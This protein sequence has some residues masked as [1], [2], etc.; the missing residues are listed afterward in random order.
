MMV[1]INGSSTDANNS[2]KLT[3]SYGAFQGAEGDRSGED[4]FI[5]HVHEELDAPREFYFDAATQRLYYF[6][7][8]S[9]GTPPPADWTFEAPM[10]A[11]LINVSG[12]ATSPVT[13]I[14]ISGITFTGA[15]AS[16]LMAHGIPSGGDWG[17]SRM[18][19]IRIEGAQGISIMNSTFTRLDGNAIF[20]S[21]YTRNV[22]IDANDFVWLG[23]SAVA[24]WGKTDGVDARAGT[25][26]WFTSVT[27]NLCHEIG[28]YEKQ[29]SC[30]FGAT[31]ASATI[32]ENIFFNM[33]RAAIN[34]NDDMAGGSSVLRNLVWNTCRESQDHGASHAC[35]R[36]SVHARVCVTCDVVNALMLP[37]MYHDATTSH[38]LQ[39]RSTAGAGSRT[40]STG[41][42]A[43]FLAALSRS[44]TRSPTTS[45]WPVVARTGDPS[46]MMMVRRNSNLCCDRPSLS[47]TVCRR[48]HY[49]LHR[50]CFPRQVRAFTSTI[51]TSKCMVVTRVILTGTLNGGW[52]PVV[53][54]SRMNSVNEVA[55]EEG[56]VCTVADHHASGSLSPHRSYSNVMAFAN[57]Y[58]SRCL[59]IMNLPHD[60]ADDF[61]AEGAGYS[62]RIH[63]HQRS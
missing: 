29:V 1:R 38:P 14:Y 7:N 12:T 6:H 22:S 31:S 53:A 32:A 54:H 41:P 9:Q 23:E 3:W 40:S 42:T 49:F 24:S 11:C 36:P 48:A 39:V 5:E 60:A 21:G 19:A 17:L 15:A 56:S 58:G 37:R 55:T 59:S 34:F 16:Y 18:G 57:V 51:T 43:P 4:W 8:A 28:M 50:L 61:F 62:Y 10:L 26:P 33:P 45:S 35:V 46:T 44:T 13:D 27:R 47:H 20:L 52:M 2:T 63:R 30:Y 25:Q